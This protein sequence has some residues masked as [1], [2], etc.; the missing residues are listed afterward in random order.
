MVL[1][2]GLGGGV[3]LGVP[4]VGKGSELD[5]CSS[6]SVWVRHRALRMAIGARVPGDGEENLEL[7]LGGLVEA[8]AWG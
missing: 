7:G 2:L 1:G 8:L 3:R 6:E 5:G 4:W